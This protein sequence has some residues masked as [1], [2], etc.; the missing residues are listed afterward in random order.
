MTPLEFAKSG[1]LY[2]GYD[3]L[4]QLSNH[5]F[6]CKIDPI[7]INNI[8]VATEYNVYKS[9]D[10]G[11]TFTNILQTDYYVRDIEIHKTN[12]NQGWIG[13]DVDFI[14]Q[15]IQSIEVYCQETK[16]LFQVFGAK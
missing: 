9:T 2:A 15:Y 1:D 14:K 10:G 11:V 4:Y 12:N 16:I 13:Q 3:Q 5:E 6:V 7:N 8:Y